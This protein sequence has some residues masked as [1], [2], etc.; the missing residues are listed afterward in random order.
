MAW[1]WP[2]YTL[3]KQSSRDGEYSQAVQANQNE[4]AK[5]RINE[6][7]KQ[8]EIALMNDSNKQQRILTETSFMLCEPSFNQALQTLASSEGNIKGWTNTNIS[9]YDS[10]STVLQLGTSMYQETKRR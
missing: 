9:N 7:I 6:T 1:H 3:P 4:V 10:K 5:Q 2:G 8:G